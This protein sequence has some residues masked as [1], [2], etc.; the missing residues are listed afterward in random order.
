MS[1]PLLLSQLSGYTPFLQLYTTT[2]STPPITHTIIVNTLTP[3]GS[4]P[5]QHIWPY[6]L[7]SATVVPTGTDRI[8]CIKAEPHSLL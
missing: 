6:G 3:W 8:V 4:D 2:I 7:K 5:K 1:M